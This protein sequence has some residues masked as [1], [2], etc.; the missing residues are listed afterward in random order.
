MAWMVRFDTLGKHLTLIPQIQIN[1]RPTVCGGG[2]AISLSRRC[3]SLGSRRYDK[4]GT[5]LR[6][7]SGEAANPSLRPTMTSVWAASQSGRSGVGEGGALISADRVGPRLSGRRA[8]ASGKE[9]A[10]KLICMDM[11]VIRDS[12]PRLFI[13]KNRLTCYLVSFFII[14]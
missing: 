13:S 4:A 2:Q 1:T 12:S 10:G 11:A 7:T 9:E 8:A 3:P 14:P 5:R 6:I